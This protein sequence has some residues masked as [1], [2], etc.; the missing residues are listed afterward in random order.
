[1]VESGTETV[2]LTTEQVAKWLGI[3][4]RTVCTWAECSELPAIKVGRQWRFHRREVSE[5]LE[6]RSSLT[7]APQDYSAATAVPAA[8]AAYRTSKMRL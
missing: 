6:R 3:A 2:M 1:M 5:W 7:R 8:T 4:P